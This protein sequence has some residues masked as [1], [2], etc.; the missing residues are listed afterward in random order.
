MRRLQ[1]QGVAECE[2]VIHPID[3]L[4]DTHGILP[5]CAFLSL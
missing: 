1:L 5:L 4:Y 3:A 2:I